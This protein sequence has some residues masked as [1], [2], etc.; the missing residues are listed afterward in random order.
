M[1]F[2]KSRVYTALNADKL[3]ERSKVLLADDLRA[4]KN[5]VKNDVKPQRLKIIHPESF[6]CRFGGYYYNYTLAY[7]IAPSVEPQYKPF[8][9]NE[10]ALKIIAKHG[11]W[12]KRNNM[13]SLVTRLD[14]GIWNKDEIEIGST[15]ESAMKVLKTYVFADDGSP[16]GVKVDDDANEDN[17]ADGED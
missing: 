4:L 8:P 10:T 12:V 2:D 14:I 17:D 7:L 6:A 13:Y 15:W 9:D 3:K 11:G 1:E 5:L 16:V